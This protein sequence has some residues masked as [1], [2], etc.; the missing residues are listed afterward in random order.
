MDDEMNSLLKN[1]T[2]ELVKRPKGQKLI[3]CKWIFKIKEGEGGNDSVRY[4]ARLV[5][6]GFTQKE[7]VD[8]TEIF[9]P[10]VKYTTIRCILALVVQFKWELDQ[11][12][13]KTAI[14]YGD[15]DEKIYMRQPVGF[16]NGNPENVVCLLKK[17]LYGLKQAPRQLY[18]TFDTFVLKHGF[19]RSNYDVCLYYKGDGGKN[20]LYLVLYVDDM[21]LASCNKTEIDDIK[22]MLKS[23]FDMKDLGQAK[24]ILDMQILRDRNKDMLF[25]Y[26]HD[27]IVKLLKRFNMFEWKPVTLPLSNHFKLSSDFCPKTDEDYDRMSKVPYANVIGSIMYLM[28]CTRP[29]LAHSISILSR[30]MGNPSEEHWNALK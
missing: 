18:K 20:S 26:R 19:Q 22:C 24:K 30:F 25:L 28:V 15:L 8:Y 16:V 12:D 13:V 29:D 3:E 17:S 7:G 27:Y 1:K 23:E 9:S 5:A 2:W 6:K 14:L 10:V 21:L 4:K 11:L